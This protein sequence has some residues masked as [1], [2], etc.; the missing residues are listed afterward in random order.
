MNYNE[1]SCI[2]QSIE[3]FKVQRVA[4][5]GCAA[6]SVIRFG[7]SMSV[8]ITRVCVGVVHTATYGEK[9]VFQGLKIAVLQVSLVQKI[10]Q[11]EYIN[12]NLSI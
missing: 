5:H 10:K 4:S 7:T 9:D 12:F 1:V 3:G 11:G 2:H 8:I 6:P